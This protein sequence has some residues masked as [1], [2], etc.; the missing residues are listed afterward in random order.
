MWPFSSKTIWQGHPD[1]TVPPLGI[2]GCESLREG[3]R[4]LWW[5][6]SMTDRNSWTAL[7]IDPAVL[8]PTSWEPWHR[9]GHGLWHKVKKNNRIQTDLFF[10]TSPTWKCWCADKPKEKNGKKSPEGKWWGTLDMGKQ[11]IN[12]LSMFQFFSQ[13]TYD[14]FVIRD[15]NTFFV[16]VFKAT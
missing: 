13:W 6:M 15:K 9:K 4:H 10:R 14:A 16:V 11:A 3:H 8:K 5:R 1:P 2:Y 7:L 12:A